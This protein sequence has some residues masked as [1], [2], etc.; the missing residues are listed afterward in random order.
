MTIKYRKLRDG[1]WGVAG[2]A[3]EVEA[4]KTITVSKSDG[5]TKV[6]KVGKILAG[7]FDDGNVLATIVKSG[8]SGGSGSRRS[9]NGG[10]RRRECDE[11]GDYVTPGTRCWE[12]GIIH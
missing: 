3:S 1:N 12:T 2:P 10:E 4:D 9:S 5:S 11:C 7:P 8:S 6:E